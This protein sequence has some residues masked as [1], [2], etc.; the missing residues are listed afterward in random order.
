MILSSKTPNC[1]QTHNLWSR[2]RTKTLSDGVEALECDVPFFECTEMDENCTSDSELDFR[3]SKLPLTCDRGQRERR[4]QSCEDFFVSKTERYE[5]AD[6][7]LKVEQRVFRK[8]NS[9][10]DAASRSF[11]NELYSRFW[12]KPQ[13]PAT[14]GYGVKE[15]WE[16][17]R[18]DT[19][20]KVTKERM[21][22]CLRSCHSYKKQ[23]HQWD[24]IVT[25]GDAKQDCNKA[26]RTSLNCIEERTKTGTYDTPGV[27][28]SRQPSRK[29]LEIL[30]ITFRYDTIRFLF[31][32]NNL[33]ELCKLI[34]G[35]T[36]T[37]KMSPI[38][39]VTIL[40]FLL[41]TNPA[42]SSARYENFAGRG[43]LRGLPRTGSYRQTSLK[44]RSQRCE[45]ITVPMCKDIGY[46]TTDMSLAH[47]TN[48]YN[49]NEA[50]EDVSIY[51]QMCYI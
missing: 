5:N 18:E 24:A 21:T 26:K 30:T 19:S 34:M 4:K 28:L 43:N 39:F 46:N 42:P 20:R 11:M 32:A 50:L 15:N 1:H 7:R 16:C 29:C 6:N 49:Q 31:F 45:N 36:R 23:S 3:D 44:T 37:S 41:L 38:A 2:T 14:T 33:F 25:K 48:K 47:I 12:S 35:G 51:I 27:Y 9:D 10:N 13:M 22:S 17:S 8:T 40:L